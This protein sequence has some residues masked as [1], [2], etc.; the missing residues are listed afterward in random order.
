MYYVCMFVYRICIP[1][2]VHYVL[3]FEFVCVVLCCSHFLIKA[4]VT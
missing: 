4:C 3:L 1:T 2:Y